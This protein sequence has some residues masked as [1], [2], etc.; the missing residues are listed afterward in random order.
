MPLNE[1]YTEV[2][3]KF[4]TLYLKQGHKHLKEFESWTICLY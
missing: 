3:N 4:W 2:E 1:E